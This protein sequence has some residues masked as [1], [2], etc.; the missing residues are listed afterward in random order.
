MEIA[1]PTVFLLKYEKMS[2]LRREQQNKC[3]NT[4]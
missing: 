4:L 2:Q 1:Q 3:N